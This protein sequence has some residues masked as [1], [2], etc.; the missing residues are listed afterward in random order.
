MSVEKSERYDHYARECL[1]LAQQANSPQEKNL[2]V[3][4][5]ETW[6]RLA[7]ERTDSMREPDGDLKDQ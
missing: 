5:A 2:L 1:R 7:L 4:M 6:R 3:Q